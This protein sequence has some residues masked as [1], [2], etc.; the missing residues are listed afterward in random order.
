[1]PPDNC[2]LAP[3][4]WVLSRSHPVQL[5]SSEVLEQDRRRDIDLIRCSWPCLVYRYGVILAS[6][7]AGYMRVRYGCRPEFHLL[8]SRYVPRR[9]RA[10][11]LMMLK[12]LYKSTQERRANQILQFCLPCKL[13]CLDRL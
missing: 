13:F 6:F 1:M 3:P 5:N 7:H 8:V 4:S 10:L 11:M 9:S 2:V 12:I